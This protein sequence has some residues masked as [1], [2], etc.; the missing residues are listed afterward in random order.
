MAGPELR[1]SYFT[2][3]GAYLA[4]ELLGVQAPDAQP[5][6]EEEVEEPAQ[7]EAP[8]ASAEEQEIEK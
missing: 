7:G 5:A 6:A 3:H 1:S 4:G 2:F 8:A